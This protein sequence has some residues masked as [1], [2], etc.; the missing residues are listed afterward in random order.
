HLVVEQDRF[1]PALAGTEHVTVGEAAAGDQTL[2]FIETAS[3]AQQVRHVYIVRCEAAGVEHRRGLHLAVDTL[4]A[5]YRDRPAHCA[6]QI[7]SSNVLLC[8]EAESDLETL[9]PSG[10]QCRELLICTLRLI[11]QP[12][13]APGGFRPRGAQLLPALIEHAVAHSYLHTQLA[14]RC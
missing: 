6:Q 1:G 14:H 3:P 4:L 5:Q 2:E 13:Q 12:P 7:G 8:I 10:C 11:A 9:L